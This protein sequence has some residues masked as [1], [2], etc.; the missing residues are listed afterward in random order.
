MN[1][2]RFLKVP[3]PFLQVFVFDVCKS[4]YKQTRAA[5]SYIIDYLLIISSIY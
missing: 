1:V 3:S 5:I 2:W 4:A